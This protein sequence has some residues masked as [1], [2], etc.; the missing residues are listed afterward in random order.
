MVDVEKTKRRLKKN[1]N[2]DYVA[3]Y[4]VVEQEEG[5]VRVAKSKELEKPLRQ[6]T[7][8]T[9]SK[10]IKIAE[11]LSK[12]IYDHL[13]T[14]IELYKEAKGKISDADMD[15]MIMAT[16]RA[17]IKF[18]ELANNRHI[19]KRSK[20]E[21]DVV[22]DLLDRLQLLDPRIEFKALEPVKVDTITQ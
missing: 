18:E 6:E 14:Q 15:D 20:W 4:Q 2:A 1:E 17:K 3:L 9:I 8:K 22:Q 11:Q 5:N 7:S 19:I 13:K 12:G 10:M 21:G 16:R